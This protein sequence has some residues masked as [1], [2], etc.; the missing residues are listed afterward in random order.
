MLDERIQALPNELQTRIFSCLAALFDNS[1]H[2][3]V[4]NQSTYSGAHPRLVE[5]KRFA[6][7]RSC[8]AY[9]LYHWKKR[10][11]GAEDGARSMWKASTDDAF[12]RGVVTAE[13]QSSVRSSHNAVKLDG[14]GANERLALWT[15]EFDSSAPNGR[16][17]SVQRKQ[18]SSHI[19][20]LKAGL[21]DVERC[22]CNTLHSLASAL[23]TLPREISSREVDDEIHFIVEA[24]YDLMSDL[25]SKNL[26]LGHYLENHVSSLTPWLEIKTSSRDLKEGNGSDRSKDI[27]VL[28]ERLET[29]V[30]KRTSGQ[31]KFE[32]LMGELKNCGDWRNTIMPSR[33]PAESRRVMPE[34]QSLSNKL[35]DPSHG[36]FLQSQS[37]KNRLQVS[38]CPDTHPH[39]TR[40]PK[41]GTQV[42]AG[43]IL[44]FGEDLEALIKLG[45][46]MKSIPGHLRIC[47]ATYN[48]SQKISGTNGENVV[49]VLREK[50]PGLALLHTSVLPLQPI[51]QWR[52]IQ[53]MNYQSEASSRWTEQEMRYLEAVAKL[54]VEVRLT[55]RWLI[56]VEWFEQQAG[57][58]GEWKQI[59]KPETV[60]D[61]GFG[62]WVYQNVA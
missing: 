44:D 31:P 51:R 47:Q 37:F 15:Y 6:E 62:S 35:A 5:L 61:G 38:C 28:I 48:Y 58:C 3:R 4:V 2:F 41:C 52:P 56:D 22:V 36:I 59:C 34:L 11:D 49:E 12:F 39:G 19:Q 53:Q 14:L 1:L 8:F 33:I 43:L 57:S 30:L 40:C 16:R 27:S 18:I 45:S 10:D 46:I 60:A 7:G 9:R 20:V 32:S 29:L 17:Y 50:L 21:K 13:W 24:L 25:A 23:G 54:K 55:W 42:I 26:D